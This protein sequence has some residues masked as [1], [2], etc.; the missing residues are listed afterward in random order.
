MDAHLLNFGLVV[1][2]IAAVSG[3]RH[4]GRRSS[5]RVPAEFGA[6]PALTAAIDQSVVD[7]CRP[8]TY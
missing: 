5:G 1:A 8:A 4:W 2:V 3:L 7:D 6:D